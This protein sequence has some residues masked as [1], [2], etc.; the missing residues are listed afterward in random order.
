MSDDFQ[1]RAAYCR[2][3][4]EKALS[5]ELKVSWLT[6]AEMWL[7]MASAKQARSAEAQ[8]QTAVDAQTNSDRV[9]H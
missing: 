7:Q 8:N 2:E 4:A 1:Q 3:M 9:F 5:D 6:T